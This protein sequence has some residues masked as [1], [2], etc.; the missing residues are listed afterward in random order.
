MQDS[1]I[2]HLIGAVYAHYVLSSC[3]KKN[4]TNKF[5]V[6]GGNYNKV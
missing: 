2:S 1:F 4:A 5:R 3:L 6:T